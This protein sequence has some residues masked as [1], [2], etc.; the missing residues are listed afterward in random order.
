MSPSI[1]IHNVTQIFMFA[2]QF[3][4]ICNNAILGRG[5]MGAVNPVIMAYSN[6]LSSA[7]YHPLWRGNVNPDS[8]AA[9]R[10]RANSVQSAALRGPG[11]PHFEGLQA[12]PPPACAFRLPPQRK[13]ARH[14]DRTVLIADKPS[15][16]VSGG[17]RLRKTE[18][19]T[20]FRAF[21]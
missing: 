11:A 17:E 19:L 16:F 3:H 14:H 12:K 6:D 9:A 21:S 5:W 7:F 13:T 10:L 20:K 15:R 1:Y 18:F 8:S 2:G 4:R